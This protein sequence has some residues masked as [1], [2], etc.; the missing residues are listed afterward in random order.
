MITLVV[1][2][3]VARTRQRLQNSSRLFQT[4]QV[5]LPDG[6]AN[7]NTLCDCFHH[8]Y[9]SCASINSYSTVRRTHAGLRIRMLQEPQ[10]HAPP[11][12]MQKHNGRLPDL[13]SFLPASNSGSGG[14]R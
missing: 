4:C 6:F 9:L 7:A 10:Y 12:Q 2:S 11:N 8:K 1:E 14:G 5:A 13:P 3:A